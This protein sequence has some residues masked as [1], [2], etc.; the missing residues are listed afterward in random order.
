MLII[1]LRDL[2]LLPDRRLSLATPLLVRLSFFR[3]PYVP[4]AYD[5]KA[6]VH[7]GDEEVVLSVRVRMPFDAPG[8]AVDVSLGERGEE[9]AGVEEADGVVV[10]VRVY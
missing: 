3:L 4:E 5:F 10:A 8:T 9:L 1:T 6:G 7:G 2:P